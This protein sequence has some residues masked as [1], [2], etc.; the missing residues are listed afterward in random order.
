M[1]EIA[2]IVAVMMFSACVPPGA[3]GYGPPPYTA[4][5][6]VSTTTAPPPPPPEE[7][8]GNATVGEYLED[9][10]DL[11][12]VDEPTPAPPTPPPPPP[13]GW[14]RVSIVSALIGPAKVD[15]THWDGPG[16]QVDRATMSKLSSALVGVNAY[17][18]AAT[19]M[20]DLAQTALDKP[21]P[22]GSA[23]L[24]TAHG[25][26]TLA[27]TMSFR[28]TFTPQWAAVTFDRVDLA[29]DPRIRLTVN[30][31]DAFQDD[32]I[33]TVEIGRSAM[34]AAVRAG[35]IYQVPVADQSLNQL[36]FVGISVS[37]V[38]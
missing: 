27:L 24:E 30:D 12:Y 10:P 26:Q 11:A 2:S 31:H 35:H 21:D 15:G 22:K 23:V 18:A 38:E 25:T 32:A 13:V 17:A 6:P 1:R 8:E 37:A 34:E 29:S 3:V 28:D 14:V 9:E 5:P 20:A 36:L 33:A 7:E 16:K 19:I 4:P